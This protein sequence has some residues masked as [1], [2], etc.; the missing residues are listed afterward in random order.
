MSVI[1]E[2]IIVI[3]LQHAQIPK[4]VL[5]VNVILDILEMDFLVLKKVSI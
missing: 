2:L 5:L 4:E 1:W 3:C